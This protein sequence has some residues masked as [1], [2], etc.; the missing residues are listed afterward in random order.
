MPGPRTEIPD[1]I[2]PH[3]IELAEQNPKIVGSPRLCQDVHSTYDELNADRTST[4]A[5]PSSCVTFSAGM[6]ASGMCHSATFT[7]FMQRGYD[8]VI[9]DCTPEA[10]RR[11][12]PRPGPGG[13]DGATHHGSMTCLP[14]VHPQFNRSFS[15]NEEE[16]RNMMFTAS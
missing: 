14:A 10:E 2:R 4:W 7:H 13:R 1:R 5:S 3:I 8:Q 12:L 16:L 9:H 6:A 11:A 15:M